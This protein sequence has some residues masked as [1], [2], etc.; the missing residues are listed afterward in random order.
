MS[1]HTI[2]INTDARLVIAPL[3]MGKLEGFTKE[4]CEKIRWQGA[5]QRCPRCGDRVYL[6][7]WCFGCGKSFS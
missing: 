5:I 6:H 2:P 3:R 4:E 1:E 7:G